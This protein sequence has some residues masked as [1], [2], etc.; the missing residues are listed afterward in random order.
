MC[1]CGS[2]FRFNRSWKLGDMAS[3][4][5]TY[6]PT[7]LL[8]D[9]ECEQSTSQDHDEIPPPPKTRPQFFYLSSLP[10]D[11]PLT[12]LPSQ[13]WA[14]STAQ[15]KL[16]PRP[17]SARDNIA[18]E[19]AWQ[20][21]RNTVEDL[22]AEKAAEG[23]SERS[24]P[25]GTASANRRAPLKPHERGG[26]VGGGAR[27][28]GERENPTRRDLPH[29]LRKSSQIQRVENDNPPT[30]R[31]EQA[32]DKPGSV[33]QERQSIPIP[34][35][36]TASGHNNTSSA[37]RPQND[38]SAGSGPSTP[39]GH[40]PSDLNVSG[41]PFAR[42]PV[43]HRQSPLLDKG[44]SIFGNDDVPPISKETKISE[45]GYME[46]GTKPSPQSRSRSSSE[47]RKNELESAV[48]VGTSR[49]HEVD[50]PKLQ[51]K[52]IY[53]NPVHDIAP[54]LRATWFYKNTMLPVEPSLANQLE[55][56]YMYLKPWT[57]T[58]QDELNS[59]V[60]NGAD[61]EMKIVHKMWPKGDMAGTDGSDGVQEPGANDS[62]GIGNM[63]SRIRQES[64]DFR[65]NQAAGL[66]DADA[67]RQFKNSSVIYVNAKDAQ[68]LRPSLL[69][70]VSR[71]RR[72]LS[73]IRKGRQIGIAVVRGFNQ[74]AWDKLNPSKLPSTTA[75]NFTK[76]RQKG[77]SGSGPRRQICYACQMEDTKPSV[78]DLVLVIHGIGQ[79]LSERVESFHFTHSINEFRRQVDIEL[80]S[81]TVWPHMRSGVE[82][83]M[84][85]PV[86]WRTT[87]SLDDADVEEYL[88]K[89]PN[90]N[91]FS[92][93]DVTPESIPAIRTLISD[94]MLDIPYYLSRHKQKM[95]QAVIKEANRIYRLWCRNNPGFRENGKVHLIAHSLGSIM[96]MDILSQQPTRMPPVDLTQAEISRTMFEFDT[97]NVFFCGS[98]AGLFLLLNK[99]LCPCCFT[100]IL[101]PSPPFSKD[102]RTDYVIATLLPRKGRR[103]PGW[104]K[105]DA[106]QGIA[107]EAGTYGC[108]AVDNLYN[109]M[110]TTDRMFISLPRA[111]EHANLFDPAIA[112]HLNATVDSD[113][114][115]SLRPASVPTSSTTFLQSVGNVFRLSSSNSLTASSPSTNLPGLTA[116]LPSNIELETHD[117]TR[118]EIAETRMGLLNDN[119]QVDF[120]IS[121]GGSA[122][123]IQYLNMLSA[124]SSYWILPD[125]VRFVVL[126]VGRMQGRDATLLAFRSEK[127]KGWKRRQA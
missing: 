13:P 127:K 44:A 14:T 12:P 36:P 49:L 27:S 40:R 19:E 123:N 84:V 38:S 9:P 34:R 48:T 32:D 11:D 52:P 108:M 98:P 85:L 92:L 63:S 101:L 28:Q 57:E 37:S 99:C 33:L 45:E 80:N 109:I 88:S 79:K 100:F 116:K 87:L 95:I 86:N 97:R 68:I 25:D 3:Q 4:L 83:I 42:A 10:I 16:P 8:Y 46:R 6:G 115:N 72:P 89:D 105:E 5:H 51:M 31:D 7:C 90:E 15:S 59:C 43:R 125:F 94:V 62:S 120:S 102:R 110:H 18:L 107:G 17:F 70:S 106:A 55:E 75:K 78:S 30:R 35:G 29:A 22:A 54:V 96:A 122:L 118:E 113:L 104:A 65:E 1:V 71:G 103:K 77:S 47:T 64:L 124:H 82:S 20:G 58:W 60:D 2:L 112:Y 126:E 50:L 119:G 41:S 53:W 74:Q 39:R 111:L 23:G 76:M 26:G 24:E 81:D 56:G 61:A 73:S 114:A 67:S 69:P 93:K 66:M 121:G 117:F 21:L 91:R